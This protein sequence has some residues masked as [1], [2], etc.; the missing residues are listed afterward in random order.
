MEAAD[1]TEAVVDSMEAEGLVVV[2]FMEVEVVG[3]A[4]MGIV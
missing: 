4:K 1:S 2:D 3:I